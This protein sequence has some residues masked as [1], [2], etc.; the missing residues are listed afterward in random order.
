M[1]LKPTTIGDYMTE[2]IQ[3]L[4]ISRISYKR[5]CTCDQ[6]WESETSPSAL[7]S[8]TC[9]VQSVYSSYGWGH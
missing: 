1:A 8:S 3:W 4:H 7:T 9:C 5:R 6:T 2:T